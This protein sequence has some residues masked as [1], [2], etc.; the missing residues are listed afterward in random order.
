MIPVV[1]V[2]RL[3]VVPASEPTT[4][5][6][7]VIIITVPATVVMATAIVPVVVQIVVVVH[8]RG[9][10]QHGRRGARAHAETVEH[11]IKAGYHLH[12]AAIARVPTVPAQRSVAR[13]SGGARA[14]GGQFAG[15]NHIVV[16]S[17]QVDRHRALGCGHDAARRPRVVPQLD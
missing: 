11:V 12:P 15:A 9:R 7:T 16:V 1:V 3:V 10:R 13:I 5:A 17:E 4:A 2:V 6:A 14:G 8:V